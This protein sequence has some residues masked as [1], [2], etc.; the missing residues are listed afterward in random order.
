MGNHK[1]NKHKHNKHSKHKR[2]K[3][4]HEKRHSNKHKH[5]RK[6]DSSSDDSISSTSSSGHHR[7]RKHSKHEHAKHTKIENKLQP[8]SHKHAHTH[9]HKKVWC[10]MCGTSLRLCFYVYLLC[11][12]LAMHMHSQSLRTPNLIRQ[13]LTN[14][15]Y[16]FNDWLLWGIASGII[17]YQSFT[18][19]CCICC[20]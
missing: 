13:L 2:H 12:L 14:G 6:R 17:P 10:A 20:V 16:L 8:H 15:G 1:H 7:S 18:V 3:K 4:K 5:K 19:N 11:G 9:K